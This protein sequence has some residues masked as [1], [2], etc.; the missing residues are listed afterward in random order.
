MSFRILVVVILALFVVMSATHAGEV[1]GSFANRVSAADVTQI[2]SAITKNRRIS[3]NVKKIEAVR[4]D[5]VVVQTTARTAVDQDTTYEFN[6]YRR[7][8][9]WTIDENSIQISMEYRDFRTH[10]PDII[11]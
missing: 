5:R 6:I 9:T 11:R 1:S 7:A 4:L 3:H 2:K 10:G 8:G